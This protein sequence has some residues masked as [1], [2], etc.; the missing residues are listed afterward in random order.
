MS[1]IV[2]QIWITK[3]KPPP[4]KAIRLWEAIA[5]KSG[6]EYKFW[7]Q[8]NLKDLKMTNLKMF[9]NFTDS[10]DAHSPSD[11]ARFEVVNKY[12]G[13]YVDCD[14]V[15]V[16]NHIE[17][18]LPIKHDLFIGVTEHNYQPQKFKYSN[19]LLSNYNSSVHICNGIFYAPLENPIIKKYVND[20]NDSLNFQRS[21]GIEFSGCDSL[22]C[23]YLTNIA[24]QYEFMLLPMYKVFFSPEEISI[25]DKQKYKDKVL[26]C[27]VHDHNFDRLKTIF[28][29]NF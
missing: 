29:D 23:F 12:G 7:D 21:N 27:Y 9:E 26:C 11:I 28:A 6:W 16:A 19:C 15:P 22:G 8:N 14:F 5:K 24:K 13:L 17:D 18:V 4:L 25:G 20:L 10:T 3:S 2:H 1:K